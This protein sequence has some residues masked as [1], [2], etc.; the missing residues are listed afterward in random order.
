MGRVSL[1]LRIGGISGG[2]RNAV[3][4]EQCPE[5]WVHTEQIVKHKYM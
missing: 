2:Y 3:A 5:Y 1:D 4:L